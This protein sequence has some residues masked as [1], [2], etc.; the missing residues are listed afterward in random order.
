LSFVVRGGEEGG[1]RCERIL[2]RLRRLSQAN[3]EVSLK[4]KISGAPKNEESED[5]QNGDIPR[6]VWMGEAGK[7]DKI[8]WRL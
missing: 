3:R 7:V 5:T 4:E 6:E 2:E 8:K 1:R